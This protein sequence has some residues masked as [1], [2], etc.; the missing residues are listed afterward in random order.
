MKYSVSD[1]DQML[2][3][4]HSKGKSGSSLSYGRDALAGPLCALEKVLQDVRDSKFRPDT[5]RSGRWQS[6]SSQSAASSSA[7]PNDERAAQPE[8]ETVSDSSSDS[9]DV[10][11]EGSS[12]DDTQQLQSVSHSPSRW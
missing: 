10:D 12:E 5:T 6:Q 4:Y 9:T 3:G 8:L 2:L 1:S 11:S 7:T